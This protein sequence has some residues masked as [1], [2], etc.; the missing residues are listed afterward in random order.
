MPGARR[1][2]DRQRGVDGALDEE[3]ELVVSGRIADLVVGLFIADIARAFCAEVGGIVGP[4]G[5]DLHGVGVGGETS[6]KFG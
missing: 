1:V 6:D 4:A 3:A 2:V 5:I